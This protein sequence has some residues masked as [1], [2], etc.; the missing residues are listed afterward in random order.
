METLGFVYLLT[1]RR[2]KLIDEF[3]YI[4]VQAGPFCAQVHNPTPYDPYV[5]VFDN[6][7]HHPSPLLHFRASHVALMVEAQP[8]LS[9]VTRLQ[10]LKGDVAESQ[11]AT[12]LRLYRRQ[13]GHHSN[14]TPAIYV[15]DSY[16]ALRAQLEQPN[17]QPSARISTAVPSSPQLMNTAPALSTSFAK[18]GPM[19]G[20]TSISSASTDV[21]SQREDPDV[22]LYAGADM[23]LME[24]AKERSITW[25]D[26][27]NRPPLFGGEELGPWRFA[28]ADD[29]CRSRGL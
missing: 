7:D 19:P 21:S 26:L 16:E 6:V 23:Q 28:S 29:I 24:Y 12:L 18:D 15:P 20:L 4:P 3:E 14:I 8:R 17:T 2:L 13:P 5:F 9:N 10:T 22:D 25:E 1:R 11:I 27:K